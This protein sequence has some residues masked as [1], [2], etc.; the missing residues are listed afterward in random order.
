MGPR[1]PSVSA[2]LLLLQVRR[3]PWLGGG[4]LPAP[5]PRFPAP[6]LSVVGPSFLLPPPPLP[7][8]FSF[9]NGLEAAPRS[10]APR[11]WEWERVESE[12]DFAH[13]LPQILEAWGAGAT[14]AADSGDPRAGR[15]PRWRRAV[16]GRGASGY[17]KAGVPVQVEGTQEEWGRPLW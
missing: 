16:E 3:V 5:T 13:S 14:L 6:I 10:W 2:L 12:R 11:R 4:R 7:R 1:Y 15:S 17:G 8:K 9:E